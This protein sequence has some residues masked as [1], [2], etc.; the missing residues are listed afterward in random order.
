MSRKELRGLPTNFS[1]NSCSPSRLAQLQLDFS[2]THQC[3]KMKKIYCYSLLHFSHHK[4]NIIKTLKSGFFLKSCLERTKIIYAHMLQL[5]HSKQHQYNFCLSGA[6]LLISLPRDLSMPSGDVGPVPYALVVREE[7]LQPSDPAVLRLHH[8]EKVKMDQL[9]GQGR[10]PS[11]LYLVP[12]I[13][14]GIQPDIT[15]SNRF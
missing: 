5:L 1:L 14:S 4:I 3:V 8:I 13:R 11:I 10:Y 2:Y 12:I 9:S 7:L 15:C 6:S